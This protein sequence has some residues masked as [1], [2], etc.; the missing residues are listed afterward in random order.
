MAIFITVRSDSSRLPQKCYKKICGKYVI[1]YVIEQAKKSKMADMVVLCTTDL[2]ED[3]KLC[4]IAKLNNID[5][6]RGSVDDKLA[7][8]RGA[9]RKFGV[10]FF[11]TADGDDLFCSSELMDLAFKQYTTNRSEFIQGANLVDGAFTYGIKTSALNKVCEIKT[12]TD[13]EMMSIYFTD[14]DLF[15]VE[16]LFNVPAIYKRNDIRMTLD[17]EDDFKFFKTVIEHFAG[18]NF[19]TQDVLSFLNDNIEIAGINFYLEGRWKQ[20]QIKNTKLKIKK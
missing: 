15:K 20:N 13:T 1:E 10:D 3:N 7:R 12:T 9:T 17:Y 16:E 19:G 11:V 5:F 8:W 14:T 6:F 4:E 18:K 2:S